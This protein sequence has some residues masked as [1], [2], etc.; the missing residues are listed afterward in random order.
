MLG[1]MWYA[2]QNFQI[3][4]PRHLG[5][6]FIIGIER[7]VLMEVSKLVFLYLIFMKTDLG[8]D[9]LKRHF[10][11]DISIRF[12]SLIPIA[13]WCS[14]KKCLEDQV[15]YSHLAVFSCAVPVA[16]DF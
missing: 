2:T 16:R 4:N 9:E 10:L 5:Y 8:K 6:M 1:D 14:V 3:Q 13:F 15:K 11:H 12:L 7:L